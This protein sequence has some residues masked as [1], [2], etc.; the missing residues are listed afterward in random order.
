MMII[1]IACLAAILLGIIG[2]ELD[3]KCL[4]GKGKNYNFWIKKGKKNED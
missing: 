1:L 4:I 2:H 3:F